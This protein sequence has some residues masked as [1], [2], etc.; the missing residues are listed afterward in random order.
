MRVSNL[1]DEEQEEIIN[2]ILRMFLDWQEEGK[3]VESM[4]GD[5]YKK[6]AD[7]II[8]AVNP[9]KTIFKRIKKYF[10]ILLDFSCFMLTIDFIFE[11]LPKLLKGT[12]DLNL[13][14]NYTLVMLVSNLFIIIGASVLVT[15]IGKTSF[16]FLNNRFYKL[17]KFAFVCGIVAFLVL[18]YVF[19]LKLSPIVIFSTNIRY[20]IIIIVI[21]RVY[22]GVKK[23]VEH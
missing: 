5:D 16:S 18:P 12:H 4:L 3:T 10:V 21:Y 22:K 1:S 9:K 15:Y 13:I 7:N 8:A 11:Y 23:I 20:V 6:F 19:S 17:E 14:Y 2:D